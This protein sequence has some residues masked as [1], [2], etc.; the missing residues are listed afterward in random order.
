MLIYYQFKQLCWLIFFGTGDILSGF[1]D[2]RQ[3]KKNSIYLKPKYYQTMS[4]YYHFLFIIHI[5]PE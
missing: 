1:F 3:V 4:L 2:E 5:P